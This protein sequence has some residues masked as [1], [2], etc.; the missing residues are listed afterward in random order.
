LQDEKKGRGFAEDRG[1]DT[2][3]LAAVVGELR[4]RLLGMEVR[5]VVLLRECD[6]MVVFLHREGQTTALHIAPGG[7][8]ARICTTGRRFQKSAFATGPSEDRLRAALSGARVSGIEQPEG[9]RRCSVIFAC[10]PEGLTLE[11]ELFGNR[12]L[13][14]LVDS[15][16]Q[17]LELARR[18][19]GLERGGTYRPPGTP[20]PAAEHEVRFSPPVLEAVDAH[21]TAL[22]AAA[23]EA[24]ERRELGRVLANR[25]RKLESR[26]AGL[27]T[28]R[29][30]IAGVD[31]LRR[32][33]DLMLAHCSDV[34]RGAAA[35]NV[36]DPERPGEVLRFELDPARTVVAQ[37]NALY[38][39][40][41]SLEDGV[42]MAATRRAEA[43]QALDELGTL[44]R[45]L[46]T[47]GDT[48][49]EGLRRRLEALGYLRPRK[50]PAQGRRRKPAGESFRRYTTLEGHQILVGRNN[51]QN[52][53]LSLRAA[54]GNDLWL[55]VGG[56]RAGSH[57]VVRLPRGKTA[58]LETLL[59][60][61]TLAIHFS[62]SRG[63]PLCEIVYT[64]CKHLRKPK[65]LPPGR[66]LVS[67]SR[68]LRIRLE[69]ERLKRLLASAAET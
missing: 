28:Q 41:R 62:R 20:P 44:E 1:L 4:D 40:A 21:F 60:A 11:V 38:K 56:G 55:H 65:G 6:D 2:D 37:A 53:R 12:G 59:D 5:D 13:W 27:R 51:A 48:D 17:I 67:Q 34:E 57:V 25:R 16:G 33:A 39:R 18:A 50:K 45:A 22:D 10:D 47:A 26:L 42:A 7:R 52:D 46:E 8:R 32:Q 54:R 24:A 68:S 35:M 31:D 63:S 49:L 64:Q 14:C 66:V 58:S 29:E 43:E 30:Q 69:P 23:E 9:E 15:E 36:P 19:R 3:E 61:G